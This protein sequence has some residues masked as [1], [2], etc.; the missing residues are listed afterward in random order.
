MRCLFAGNE[1]GFVR[2]TNAILLLSFAAAAFAAPQESF[3]ANLK[4]DIASGNQAWV[5]GLKSGDAKLAASSYGPDAVHCGADGACVTGQAAAI[6]LYQSVIDKF[7]RATGGFV[8]SESLHVDHDLAYESGYAEA[9]FPNA[10]MRRGRFSTV[11]K[12]QPDGHWKIFRNMSL[13]PAP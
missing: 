3:P 13:P 5:D 11:W 7:G 10:N 8:R 12:L 1:E 2:W 4:Q 6:A 9:R